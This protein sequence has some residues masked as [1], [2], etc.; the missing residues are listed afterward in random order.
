MVKT[1]KVCDK[2]KNI[3]SSK[4]IDKQNL[5][6]LSSIRYRRYVYSKTRLAGDTRKQNRKFPRVGSRLFVVNTKTYIY[7]SNIQ[8]WCWRHKWNSL[9]Q[10]I[11]RSLLKCHH[12]GILQHIS[13]RTNK[14]DRITFVIPRIYIYILISRYIR[15]LHCFYYINNNTCCSC[16]IMNFSI[17]F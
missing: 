5:Y 11:H 8:R 2:F 12:A 10:V 13:F 1:K 3:C 7:M 6:L 17:V 16:T 4:W 9:N 14:I 15:R